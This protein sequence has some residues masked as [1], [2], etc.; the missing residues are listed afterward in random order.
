MAPAE[1]LSTRFKIPYSLAVNILSRESVVLYGKGSV[2]Q[3]SDHTPDQLYFVLS[4]LC[5]YTAGKDLTSF[6]GLASEGM[7]LNDMYFME[8]NVHQY[9]ITALTDCLLVQLDLETAQ[10]LCDSRS[11]FKDLLLRT[12]AKK[13]SMLNQIYSLQRIASNS[14]KVA[15]AL[16]LLAQAAGSN[17]IPLTQK[18]FSMLIGLSR[19]TAAKPVGE[20]IERGIIDFHYGEITVLDFDALQRITKEKEDCL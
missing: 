12:T 8:R 6:Y 13:L 7:L 5:I 10:N 16:L 9:A 2:I 4:G 20:L 11:E 1:I 17:T 19:N 15:K 14:L 3:Q 18:Q